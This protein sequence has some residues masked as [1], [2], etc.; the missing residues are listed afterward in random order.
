[1]YLVIFWYFMPIWAFFLAI[2]IYRDN[3]ENLSLFME[4]L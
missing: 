1:M 2:K 4:L 3:F